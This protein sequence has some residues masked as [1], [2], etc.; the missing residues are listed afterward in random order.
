M[1]GRQNLP[2][3]FARA[4]ALL[5]GLLLAQPAVAQTELPDSL[6]GQSSPIEKATTGNGAKTGN[7][8]LSMDIEQLAKTPVVVPSMD[9]PVTTVTKEQSTVGRSPA[10][11]FVI[12]N[13]MI[14]R[15]GATCIPEALRMA[16]G[17]QVSQ[18]NSNAW[19]IAIRGFN[20]AYSNKLLVLIDGRTVYN[21]DF[22]GVYWDAQEVL[23]ED[24]ERIEVVRGPGG[25]LWGANAVNGVI[26]VITKTAKDTQGT[27]AMA[28]GGTQ[29]NLMDA[30]RYGGHIG[31]DFHYRVYGKQFETGAG[32]APGS[33]TDDAWS[34]GRF[35]F[36]ADWQPGSDKS[37]TVT[38]QGDHYV[39]GTDNGLIPTN[40]GV[41]ER[42]TGENLLMRWRHVYDEDSDWSLQAYYD[43]VMRNS[44]LQTEQVRTFDV[45]FQYHFAMTDRQRITCGAGFR[46]VESYYAGG[47]TFTI[48]YP[49]QPWWTTNYTNQFV[50]DEIAL[51]EDKLTLTLGCKL[52]QNPYTGM[53]YQPTARLLR[54]FDAKHSAWCAVSRAVRT[55][56]RYQD[57]VVL[58]LPEV[59]PGIYP[60]VFGQSGAKSET[61]IAY[62][63]GYR[64]QATDAFSW[65]IATFYNTYDHLMCSIPGGG[66][67]QAGAIMTIPLYLENGPRAETYGVELSGNYSVSERWRIFAQY[68]VFQLHAYLEPDQTMEIGNDPCNQC[69]LRSSWDLRDN[70]QFDVTAR[71]VDR[72]AALDIASYFTMDMRLAWRPQ[73]N[74]ELAVVGQNLLQDHHWEYGGGTLK[75]PVYA[76]QVPRSVYGTVTW[77]H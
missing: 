5:V 4:W 44:T 56:T 17:V 57:Q 77:R 15:S 40:L 66:L 46:N 14:R 54:S 18:V 20:S 48:W 51:V 22:A 45:D 6:P 36:R 19:A 34:Q 39:G 61:L 41:S 1:V 16:P 62:E 63:L 31:D 8:I 26:N 38:I 30:A 71:A 43:N 73:K 65:D 7:D 68:S 58:T 60:Q 10:A 25:T 27:Y 53:E 67:T 13:E 49:P 24:V 75:S 21:P 9:I 52:E 64:E 29:K 11:V 74:W 72:L 76:S 23:L 35:G 33:P 2:P 42:Q 3:R 70:V 47:D 55:P 69:Y 50:Q 37:N 59:Y 28:G 32:Y 12:T